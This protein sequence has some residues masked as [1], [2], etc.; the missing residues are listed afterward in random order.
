LGC[1]IYEMVAGDAP[2]GDT[3]KD[4]KFAILNNIN[5][6]AVRFPMSMS[7]ELKDLLAGLMNKNATQRSS[8]GHFKTAPWVAGVEWSSLLD[9]TIKPPWVPRQSATPDTSNFLPWPDLELPTAQAPREAVQYCTENIKV[10]TGLSLKSMCHANSTP[11]QSQRV[12]RAGSK[13]PPP[14]QRVAGAGNQAE[15]AKKETSSEPR[16]SL[17]RRS[18]E[19]RP[20]EPSAEHSLDHS[21]HPPGSKPHTPTQS[22]VGQISTDSSTASNLRKKGKQK[23]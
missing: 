22:V 2:F 19:R 4:N 5:G 3:D 23:K 18:L 20:Q 9:Q 12:A 14:S 15:P 6:K 13:T 11:T 21:H 16:K 10:D 8:W 17:D 1:I 7:A